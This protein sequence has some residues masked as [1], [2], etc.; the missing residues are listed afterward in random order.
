MLPGDRTLSPLGPGSGLVNGTI[1]GSITEILLGGAWGLTE[2]VNV[3][4]YMLGKAIPVATLDTAL[5][6]FKTQ[7][8]DKNFAALLSFVKDLD[9]TGLINKINELGLNLSDVLAL[10]KANALVA[11]AKGLYDDYPDTKEFIETITK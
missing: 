6:G 8:G 10:L 9:F 5:K 4:I 2:I 3:G 1:D 11:N 7:V